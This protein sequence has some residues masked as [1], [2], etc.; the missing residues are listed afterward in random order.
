MCKFYVLARE[1]LSLL[2][3]LD[4]FTTAI[5]GFL[6]SAWKYSVSLL[7]K[8]DQN[9][10]TCRSRFYGQSNIQSP[11]RTPTSEAANPHINYKRDRTITF[12]KEYVSLPEPYAWLYSH[13]LW[14]DLWIWKKWD[15]NALH[16]EVSSLIEVTLLNMKYKNEW[17]IKISYL[18]V[19]QIHQKESS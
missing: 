13:Q 11:Q 12:N 6:N 10:I 9:H 2:H 5:Q 3:A 1:K 19:C 4:A 16:E 18:I 15:V 7:T 17:A 14:R 8:I